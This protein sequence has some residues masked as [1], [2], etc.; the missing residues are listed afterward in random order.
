MLGVG[1]TMNTCDQF[2]GDDYE[3]V[4]MKTSRVVVVGPKRIREWYDDSNNK[5]WDV[6]PICNYS[7][8]CQNKQCHYTDVNLKLRRERRVERGQKVD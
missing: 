4:P 5:C 7:F 6:Y 8:T 1:F 2:I 3:T